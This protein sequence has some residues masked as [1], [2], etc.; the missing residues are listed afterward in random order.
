[1]R[2]N[3]KVVLQQP[4]YLGQGCGGP[5]GYLRNTK[6]I[7]ETLP[8]WDTRGN[9]EQAIHLLSRFLGGGWNLLRIEVRIEPQTLEL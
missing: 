6:R 5:G 2:Q 7:A 1:M 3:E 8:R 4:L 9:L